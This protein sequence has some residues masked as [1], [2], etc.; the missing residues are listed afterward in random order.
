MSRRSVLFFPGDQAKLLRKAPDTGADVVVF[1]LE[2]A[3]ASS[4]KEAGR[5]TVRTVLETIDPSCEVCVRIN[6]LHDGGKRDVE[7]VLA[8]SPHVD[9]IM[10]P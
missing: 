3:V 10:L 9:S 1:D 8:D 7:A 2:D 6:P 4:K 5:E